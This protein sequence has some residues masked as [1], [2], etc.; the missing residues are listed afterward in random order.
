M[1]LANCGEGF[2]GYTHEQHISVEQS[3]D[4][5]LGEQDNPGFEWKEDKQRGEA[6]VEDR[7]SSSEI[8]EKSL[9]AQRVFFP[10]VESNRQRRKR[11]KE[12]VEGWETSE[13]SGRSLS[14]SDLAY[15]WK[16]V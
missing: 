6:I 16:L 1:T 14:D 11:E 4:K 2:S 15:R 9:E 5:E 7:L 3:V 13:L 12:K 8:E 10:E